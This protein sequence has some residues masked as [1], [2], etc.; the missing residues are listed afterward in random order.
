MV[1]MNT[2]TVFLPRPDTYLAQTVARGSA[3]VGQLDP[4]A[5]RI[6]VDY[7]G[8]IYGQINLRRFVE[9]V[10]CAADRQASDYPS[11]SRAWVPAADLTAIGSFTAD[12]GQVKL[13][14]AA[15]SALASWLDLV[16]LPAEEL[17]RPAHWSRR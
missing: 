15:Q 12:S 10:H 3:L 6:Q 9:R 17:I 1:V 5:E 14:P 16:S 7:E 4:A 8:G 13:D 11:G 2:F